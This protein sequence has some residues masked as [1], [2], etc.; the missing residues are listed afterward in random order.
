MQEMKE[1]LEVAKRLETYLNDLMW[2]Q[3]ELARRADLSIVTVN[4]AVHDL[5][6]TKASA[7]KIAKVIGDELGEKLTAKD[8][9]GLKVESV[10]MKKRDTRK[11]TGKGE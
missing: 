5:P 4:R 9:T 10:T 3:S 6:I 8:F 1:G 11:R 2:S 7:L